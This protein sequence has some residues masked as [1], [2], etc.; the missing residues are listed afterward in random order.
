VEP[1]SLEMRMLS[2]LIATTLLPSPEQA[3]RPIDSPL[4]SAALARVQVSPEFVEQ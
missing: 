4:E 3:V 2:D 1:E